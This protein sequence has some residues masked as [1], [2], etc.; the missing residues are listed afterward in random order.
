MRASLKT[1]MGLVGVDPITAEYDAIL[2]TEPTVPVMLQLASYRGQQ[3]LFQDAACTVPVTSIGDP[4]GGVRRPVI[5]DILATQSTDS[6]R[7]VWHG[8]EVGCRFGDGTVLATDDPTGIGDASFAFS[9]LVDFPL[10]PTT[11]SAVVCGEFAGNPG[12]YFFFDNDGS[13]GSVVRDG[14]GA[15]V[16]REG[17]IDWR[18]KKNVLMESRVDR[19]TDTLHF[20]IDGI[21]LSSPFPAALD[22]FDNWPFSLGAQPSGGR[23][24]EGAIKYSL[25][26]VS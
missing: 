10:E 18:G 21:E 1:L 26:S 17:S 13:V 12:W 4:V 22:P 11:A 9:A 7:P 5:D 20:E 25:V 6:A 23:S 3:I 19:D 15:I 16:V 8:P 2:A 14:S 24:F